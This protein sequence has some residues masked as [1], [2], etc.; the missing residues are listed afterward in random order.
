MNYENNKMTL[1]R[2]VDPRDLTETLVHLPGM[3]SPEA[4]SVP[5]DAKTHKDHLR[6]TCCN[7]Q[8]HFHRG[9]KF[10]MADRDLTQPAHFKRNR[11]Q[12]HE[13]NCAYYERMLR[14]LADA[15]HVQ[16]DIDPTKGYSF[17]FKIDVDLI[18]DKFN[19]DVRPVYNHQ[20]IRNSTA[21]QTVVNDPR[22]K[23][24]ERI[25]VRDME[26]LAHILPQLDNKRLNESYVVR[27]GQIIS[28]NDFLV[29]YSRKEPSVPLHHV[30]FEKLFNNLLTAKLK[31][32]E[33]RWQENERIMCMLEV[34]VDNVVHHEEHTLVE[35]RRVR[36]ILPED[37]AQKACKQ[38]KEAV[39]LNPRIFLETEKNP[40]LKNA[41]EKGG[42]YLVFGEVVMRKL[43]QSAYVMNVSVT[44]K[45]QITAGDLDDFEAQRFAPRLPF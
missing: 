4:G 43:A 39:Y 22:L 40:E 42:R 28:W 15:A 32:A 12:R 31:A 8:I 7:A 24:L 27:N 36:Y 18:T 13:E 34:Q 16:K 25:P 3:T 30:K 9:S 38:E 26:E 6:C 44:K 45:E 33:S 1:A 17:L 37:I 11:G 19:A 23:G 5:Y 10:V 35:S 29:Q 2:Y 41:M 14:Q 21:F 20:R